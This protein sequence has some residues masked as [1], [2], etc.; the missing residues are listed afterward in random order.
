MINSMLDHKIQILKK[1]VKKIFG[2]KFDGKVIYTGQIDEYKFGELPYRSVDMW[3]LPRKITQMITNYYFKRVYNTIQS[4]Q[5][6]I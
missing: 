6:K 3:V 5:H 2:S 4:L 1:F